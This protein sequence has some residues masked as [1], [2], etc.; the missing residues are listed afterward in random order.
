MIP[1]KIEIQSC[2]CGAIL[3]F[4]RPR[5]P[6]KLPTEYTVQRLNGS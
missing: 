5:E 2:I 6:G 3:S 4:L 1:R